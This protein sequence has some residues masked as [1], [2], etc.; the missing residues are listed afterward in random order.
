MVNQKNSHSSAS[1][2]K[3]L[4]KK[5]FSLSLIFNALLTISYALGVLGGFYWFFK[6][7]Q[8]FY[9]FIVNGNVFWLVIFAAALNIVPSARLGRNLKTGRLFFHHYFYGVLVMVLG[10]IFVVAF[11]SV[12]LLTLFLIENSSLP[13]NAAR[14]LILG[15]FTLILDDLPDT[16]K[17]VKTSI[18]NVKI[19]TH[20]YQKAASILRFALGIITFYVLFAV[21]LAMYQNTLWVTLANF[22][23][24]GTLFIT[25]VSAIIFSK[26]KSLKF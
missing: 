18:K 16:S 12:S 17:L 10:L 26:K 25:S 7:W 4:A 24:L 5:L 15:G 11:T 20:P 19:K 3:I 14:F 23:L 2:Y 6:G 21:G 1:K 22:I 8:P 9:P 13:V